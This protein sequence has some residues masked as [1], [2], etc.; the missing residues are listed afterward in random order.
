M[1]RF[2]LISAIILS[3][4]GCK[5]DKTVEAPCDMQKVYAENA[6]RVSI[7]TGVWGTIS[8]MEGNCM[9]MVGAK[10]GNCK[11]CPI[12]RTIKI[13]QYTLASNATPSLNAGGFFDEFNTEL[14]AQTKS[15]KNG[16][17]QVNLPKGNYSIAVVENGKL[18]VTSYD[19]QGGLNPFTLTGEVENINISLTYKAAF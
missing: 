8:S 6:S 3:F 17:F 11:N 12:E 2:F 4:V 10:N 13:Y 16:F 15:D 18:Y 7:T 1:K 14:I 5:K 9:P 19:A